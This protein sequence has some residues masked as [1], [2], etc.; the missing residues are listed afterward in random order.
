[1]KSVLKDLEPENL[2]PLQTAKA[3]LE[4]RADPNLQARDWDSIWDSNGRVEAPI[5]Y[6]L[7]GTRSTFTPEIDVFFRSSDPSEADGWMSLIIALEN[8][9]MEGLLALLVRTRTRRT[10]ACT[11]HCTTHS[12]R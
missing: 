1:M 8:G 11:Q 9:D 4:G 6:D 7:R 5:M 12:T 3:L 2:M 10:R